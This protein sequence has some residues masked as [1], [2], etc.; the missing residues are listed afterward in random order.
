MVAEAVAAERALAESLFG[1]LRRDGLDEPGVTRDPYGAGE[2]RAHATAVA[3]AERLG[4]EEGRLAYAGAG[5]SGRLAV[6]DGAELTPTFS[7]A[8]E[9]LLLLIAGGEEALVTAVEGAEDDTGAARAASGGTIASRRSS[10]SGGQPRSRSAARSTPAAG[11]WGW[12]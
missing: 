8:R 9:R 11:P 10:G 4:L 3:A 1:A 5:T 2:Q 7:W 6:Q 12:P